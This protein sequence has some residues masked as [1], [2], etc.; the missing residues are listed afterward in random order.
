MNSNQ[1]QLIAIAQFE[2]LIVCEACALNP[3]SVR[4]LGLKSIFFE[5]A[6]FCKLNFQKADLK[7]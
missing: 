1:I 4:S 3:A 7:S 2:G 6:A 5:D